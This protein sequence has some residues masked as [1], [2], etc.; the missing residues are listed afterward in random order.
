M[1]FKMEMPPF[2]CTEDW[3]VSIASDF[4]THDAFLYSRKFSGLISRAFMEL[5]KQC[6]PSCLLFLWSLLNGHEFM[7]HQRELSCLAIAMYQARTSEC[8]FSL[9]AH[10]S[11]VTD[12]L[13]AGNPATNRVGITNWKAAL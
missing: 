13:P 1:T 2:V 11:R 5:V 12:G 3:H 7:P 4:Q 9:P 8:C 10:F 6:G